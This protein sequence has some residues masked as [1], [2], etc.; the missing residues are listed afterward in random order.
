MSDEKW[1]RED[2]LLW[3]EGGC[4]PHSLYKIGSEHEKF[5][6]DEETHDPIAYRRED[7]RD[8]ETLLKRLCGCGWKEKYEGENVV[9]LTHDGGGAIT[10]EPSGQLELSGALQTDLHGVCRETREHLR[11]VVREGRALGIGFLGLGFA[12]E[13]VHEEMPF[14]PKERYG[15]MRNYMPRVG[16]RGLM[17]MHRSCTVQVNLDYGSEEDM[18]KK[19]RV[20]MALQG[21]VGALFA[22]S[23]FFE[24][25]D[26]GMQSFRLHVWR[27]VDRA[28]CGLVES[29]FGEGF[30]FSSWVD[31]LVDVVPMYFLRRGDKVCDVSGGSFLDLME[32][33]LKGFEGEYASREDWE[34]HVSVAFPDVRLKRYIEMRGADAGMLF[35]LC[36][37][38]SLWVG[39]LYDDG[40]LD[41]V[42]DWLKD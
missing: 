4:K 7:G 30:G 28:R 22:N 33:R 5:L 27:D 18:R 37:L 35:G 36:G 2:G 24:G 17:M 32:G 6:F 20:G 40:V 14:M 13:W 25:K 31:Y 41:G 42:Y 1:T 38:P 11:D 9:G 12:P 26:S 3:F 29:V 8:I 16:S 39:L 34:D 15:I 10:L 23:P 19:M 21:M